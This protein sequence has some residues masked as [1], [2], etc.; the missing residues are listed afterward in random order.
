M[1]HI[2]LT[3]VFLFLTTTAFSQL[4]VKIG[5]QIWMKKN[6]D[7]DKFR[8]GDPIPEAKSQEDLEKADSLKQPI[9]CY[10]EFDKKFAKKYGKI[11]NWYAVSDKRGLTP[12]GWHIPSK[13]EWNTLIKFAHQKYKDGTGIESISPIIDSILYYPMCSGDY[14][15]SKRGWENIGETTNETDLTGFSALPGGYYKKLVLPFREVGYNSCWWSSS[16]V[17]QDSEN[18]WMFQ[19]DEMLRCYNTIENMF[20]SN[21]SLFYDYENHKLDSDMYN[22]IYK[23]SLNEAGSHKS[24]CYSVRCIKD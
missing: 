7:V 1:R 19:L 22:E 17:F 6:L 10:V 8:N 4:E 11:Y 18:A 13:T 3:S 20:E 16:E 21:S 12:N 23:S 24:D 9:W 15:K 5:N 14:F 2:L